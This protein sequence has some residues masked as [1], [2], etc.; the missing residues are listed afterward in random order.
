[1]K[2]KWKT[3]LAIIVAC[4]VVPINRHQIGDGWGSFICAVITTLIVFWLL[5]GAIEMDKEGK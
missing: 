1:M 4:M 3:P 5:V 2:L